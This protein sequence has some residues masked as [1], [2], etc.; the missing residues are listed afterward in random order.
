MRKGAPM[1][2]AGWFALYTTVVAAPLLVATL[3]PARG[4]Q[5]FTA[6]LGAAAGWV[7]F[8]LLAAEFALVTRVRAAAAAFGSDALLLFHRLMA[9]AALAFLALHGALLAPRLPDPFARAPLERF[10]AL[11]AWAVL[12]LIVSTVWR[13][14]LRWSHELWLVTHRVLALTVVVA[15]AWHVL[16]SLG[17]GESAARAVVWT[18]AGAALAL[19]AAQRLVRPLH[20]QRRPW[21][22]VENRDEGASTRTLVLRAV[23][24]SGLRFAPGQFVWIATPRRRLLVEEHPI[25]I[26]SSPELDGGR[27]LELAI[28]ALGDWSR[29]IVPA[30]YPGQRVR[31]DGPFGAFTCDGVAA[32][33][34]VLV[35]GGVG[36]TPMRSMLLAMRDRGDR[37]PAVLFFAAHD[38]SRAM[39][40]GELERLQSE[41]DLH[42]VFVF[43]APGEG[44]RC[45]RGF[46]TADILRKHL[47]ADLRF[48]SFFVCGPV[49]MMKAFEHIADELGV[50]AGR[51]HTERFDVV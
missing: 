34:L 35:A 27:T 9:L 6:A 33:R 18:Y 50:P 36:V 42:V 48:T 46:L 41:I 3:F 31:V 13:R 5:E 28:K 38:R 44:E 8:A 24:H 26:A 16:V 11:A 47:P 2:S 30:L 51:I 43:E 21:E 23:G 45:E 39:F 7:A 20:L 1:R 15:G 19:F 17:P 4:P 37:R 32:Q 14:R 29:E 10:G 40:A 12:L 22:L 49:P 25:T